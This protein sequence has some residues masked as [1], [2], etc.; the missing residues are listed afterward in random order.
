MLVGSHPESV[1]TTTED[2]H[3]QVDNRGRRAPQ[4]D[5]AQIQDLAVFE[6][7]ETRHGIKLKGD[8]DLWA[9]LVGGRTYIS[10]IF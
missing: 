7:S 10:S 5:M 2:H 1:L 8:I 3:V 6:C 4:S 9:M